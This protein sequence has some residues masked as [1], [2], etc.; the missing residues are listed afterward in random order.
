[1]NATEHEDV[2]NSVIDLRTN[3]EF[4]KQRNAILAGDKRATTG[5]CNSLMDYLTN[6][7]DWPTL[8]RTALATSS[9]VTGKR[10]TD[11]LVKVMQAD[12]EV[13]AIRAVEDMEAA[14][15]DDPA[16]YTPT[17]TQRIAMEWRAA[18]A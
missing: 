1:M 15:K 3:D 2:R 11:L 10:F 7:E 13:V 9:D 17:R 14:A 8:I 6:S 16:N 4:K 12:A 18:G 5:A